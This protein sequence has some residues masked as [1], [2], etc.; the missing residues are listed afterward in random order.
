M[1]NYAG[2]EIGDD[3]LRIM[4]QWLVD[5]GIHKPTGKVWLSNREICRQIDIRYYCG[6][7]GF[8]TDL[9]DENSAKVI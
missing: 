1:T 5:S 4:Y 3:K 9:L 8:L 7:V 6:I 2:L